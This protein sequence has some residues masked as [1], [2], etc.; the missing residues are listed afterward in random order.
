[1]GGR[2]P[3][4]PPVSGPAV[5][6]PEIEEMGGPAHADLGR[7]RRRDVCRGAG[8]DGSRSVQ[9][10]ERE[11]GSGAG[12][13]DAS[14]IGGAGRR[15][16]EGQEKGLTMKRLLPMSVQLFN[17]SAIYAHL[18]RRVAPQ[19]PGFS[20][21]VAAADGGE[22]PWLVDR[23]LSS[24]REAG[25]SL[26]KKP[27]PRSQVLSFG[28]LSGPAAG[29]AIRE[30]GAKSG[31]GKVAKELPLGPENHGEDFCD[32]PRV[33]AAPGAALNH[34]AAG[35]PANRRPAARPGLRHHAGNVSADVRGRLT[36]SL[37][38]A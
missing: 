15:P 18:S 8:M 3:S 29:D 32:Q 7:R 9:Q 26:R 1:M 5:P 34:G 28:K 24:L 19:A 23:A 36:R 31:G 38:A 4:V 14:G 37:L 11:A 16:E 25:L 21:I 35:E 17:W 22:R 13:T 20:A 6:D 12:A 30:P 33:A 10:R 2:H 27:R